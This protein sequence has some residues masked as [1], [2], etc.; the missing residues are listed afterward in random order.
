MQDEAAAEHLVRNIEEGDV[1]SY[2]VAVVMGRPVGRRFGGDEG[3]L[4]Y[5]RIA[6]VYIYGR[7]V[8]LG[9]PVAGNGDGVPSAHVET[10]RLETGQPAVGIRTPMEMPLPVQ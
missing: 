6:E 9:L 2:G 5:E 7:A 1:L 4:P 3:T 10:L 8:S